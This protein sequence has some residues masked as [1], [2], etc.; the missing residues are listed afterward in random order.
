M[1]SSCTLLHPCNIQTRSTTGP[2]NSNKV[3]N[4][5][6][7]TPLVLHFHSP[8]FSTNTF[9]SHRAIPVLCVSCVW[10]IYWLNRMLRIQA[11]ITAL[12]LSWITA[13]CSLFLRREGR[14]DGRTQ[15]ILA[16][17]RL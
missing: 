8:H 3:N 5:D 11:T 13:G 4:K 16:K 2:K 6:S 1:K 17:T 7:T 15:R 10:M 12:N 9:S 14:E